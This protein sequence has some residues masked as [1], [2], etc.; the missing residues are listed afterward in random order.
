MIGLTRIKATKLNT[1]S[2]TVLTAYC[3]P[4]NL[5]EEISRS[6]VPAITL[7]VSFELDTP[8][9]EGETTKLIS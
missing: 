1:K 6:G 7:V 5:V 4:E 9:I 8:V 2:N 3:G